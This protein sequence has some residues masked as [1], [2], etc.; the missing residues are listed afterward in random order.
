MRENLKSKHRYSNVIWS[1]KNL[2]HKA[3]LPSNYFFQLFRISSFSIQAEQIKKGVICVQ[4]M[5]EIHRTKHGRFQRQLFT[6]LFL[7][8]PAGT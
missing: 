6:H 3:E 4:I 7:S 1:E 5:L 2:M 8:H